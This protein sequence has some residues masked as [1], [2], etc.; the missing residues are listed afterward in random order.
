MFDGA[1]D[2]AQLLASLRVARAN[3]GRAPAG[4][5]VLDPL[6]EDT[7]ESLIVPTPDESNLD[8]DDSLD[9]ETEF[10][11][12][13]DPRASSAEDLSAV[14]LP[15]DGYPVEEPPASIYDA[16]PRGHAPYGNGT[17]VNRDA[18]IGPGSRAAYGYRPPQAPPEVLP[19]ASVPV[20]AESAPE[21]PPPGLVPLLPHRIPA[22]PDV[23]DV[24]D[25]EFDDYDPDA[26]ELDR[27]ASRLRD[28]EAP[29]EPPADLD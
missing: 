10:D 12:A 29:A 3:I 19:V 17:A 2:H 25:D 8:A 7:I 28:D 20:E 24:P 9:E 1:S 14:D 15:D 11:G 22:P 18:L 16:I 21:P 23:P 26:P 13:V 27:I 5:A 4:N 6:T